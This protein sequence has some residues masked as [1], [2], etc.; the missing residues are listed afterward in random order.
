MYQKYIQIT[1][2]ESKSRAGGWIESTNVD[3]FNRNG[4]FIQ[5]GPRGITVKKN[6]LILTYLVIK[7]LIQLNSLKMDSNY[8]FKSNNDPYRSFVLIDNKLQDS[9]E[10][11]L[12]NEKLTKILLGLQYF[13]CYFNFIRQGKDTSMRDFF[14]FLPPQVYNS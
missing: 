4:S 10:F 6:D 2:L 13:Y 3:D 5:F 1:I 14:S 11:A 12:K 7:F 9:R 8:I